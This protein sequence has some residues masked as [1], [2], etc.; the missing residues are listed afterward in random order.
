MRPTAGLVVIAACMFW[1]LIASTTANAQSDGVAL[2]VQLG[3]LSVDVDVDVD[4]DA[5]SPQVVCDPGDTYI[6]DPESR[7]HFYQCSNGVPYRMPCPDNL[8]FD[9]RIEP[10][11]VCVWPRDYPPPASRLAAKAPSS[12]PRRCGVR[13]R[14]STRT[15]KRK[16]V[17]RSRRCSRTQRRAARR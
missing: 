13:A 10:G 17:S 9:P 8:V 14:T 7:H 15:A 16:A 12:A 5:E 11:P 1:S 4:A 6:P 2:D 3:D